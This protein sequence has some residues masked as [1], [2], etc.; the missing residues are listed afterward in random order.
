M[1]SKIA[2]EPFQSMDDPLGVIRVW[3]RLYTSSIGSGQLKKDKT[4]S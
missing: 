1:A 3:H 4:S 2:D